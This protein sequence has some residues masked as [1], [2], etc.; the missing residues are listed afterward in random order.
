MKINS[1][2]ANPTDNTHMESFTSILQDAHW[3]T[4]LTAARR[5]HRRLATEI[6]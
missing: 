4:S 5:M 2:L 3:F 1:N 6:Q